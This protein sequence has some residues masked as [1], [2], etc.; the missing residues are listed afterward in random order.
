[1]RFFSKLYEIVLTWA[2]HKYA[3]YYLSA[4]SFAESFVLPYPPP[5]VLLAPI[6]LKN[7]K[8]G[9]H[10][11]FICTFFS[12]LGGV[13]GFVLG[14]VAIDWLTP[15]LQTMNYL[16]TLN[17]VQGC[18]AQYGV[19]IIMV[20]GFSPIP[21]KIFTIGAGVA[22]MAF[23]PFVLISFLARGARFF[24][25]ALLVKK[26]GENCDVWL[27]KYIDRLGYA[28]ILIVIII[29]GVKYAYN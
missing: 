2:A 16:E 8:R 15:F 17:V 23:L 1:M 22:S 18:F 9:Y 19:L 12:V 29:L 7:P 27:K 6:V 26:F 14:M 10:S 21:Y 20:A 24:L 25:V 13:V 11:A 3:L 28:L 4:L 5:D